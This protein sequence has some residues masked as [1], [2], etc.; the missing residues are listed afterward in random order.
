MATDPSGPPIPS[1]VPSGPIGS[2]SVCTCEA[3]HSRIITS[4][5]SVWDLQ[6]RRVHFE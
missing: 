3:F 4:S 1:S 5:W 2:S 6:G